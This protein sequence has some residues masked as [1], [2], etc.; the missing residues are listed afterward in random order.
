MSDDHGAARLTQRLST[1]EPKARELAGRLGL[2]RP[3]VFI[4]LETTGTDPLSD[5]IVEIGAIK[6]Y[7]SAETELLHERVN[8]SVPIPAEAS[9]VHGIT[10]DLV[11]ER[12]VFA[13]M[14]ST[15]A[16]FLRGCDLAGF[17]IARFDIPLLEAEFG[18]AGIEFSISDRWVVDAL[19]VFHDRERRD[20]ATAV[21]F[22][23]GR[24]IEHAHS[25]I[26]D[27][28]SSVEVL[29]GQ[30]ERYADLPT[31]LEEL[32]RL[33][34]PRRPDPSWLDPAGRLVCHD[35]EIL[36]NFGKYAGRKLVDVTREDPGYLDWVLQQDF[37]EQ[38]KETIANAR[39]KQTDGND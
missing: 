20:L 28:M 10:D 8:P 12:P 34:N 33:S 26:A 16:E 15:V 13:A 6:L 38:V 17:G 36:M 5:R 25:A 22:Y 14:A 21:D 37:S 24:E 35:D 39:T 2:L 23:A 30:F 31:E 1:L 11:A 3:L 29:W 19:R 27:A 4:D 7:P 32:D 9:A 18:R